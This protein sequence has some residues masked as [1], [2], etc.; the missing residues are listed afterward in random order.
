MPVQNNISRHINQPYMV[1]R[2]TVT[3]QHYLPAG[4]IESEQLTVRFDVQILYGRV[5]KAA[6]LKNLF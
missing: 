1:A 2:C 5:Y 6:V 3:R 4:R